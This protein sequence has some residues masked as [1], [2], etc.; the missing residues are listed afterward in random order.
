ML[1][2]QIE[3]WF[4]GLA[5]SS[6]FRCLKM[7]PA[8]RRG[9]PDRL[10]LGKEGKCAFVEFKRP[11]ET[12]RRIQEHLRAELVER[13][14]HVAVVD[15]YEK[16]AAFLELVGVKVASIPVATVTTAGRPRPKVIPIR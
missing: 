4:V 6:G 13:G 5:E 2:R 1:E 12:L 16:A 9:W 10:V 8:G 15:S 14:F 3:R 11:G 7:T